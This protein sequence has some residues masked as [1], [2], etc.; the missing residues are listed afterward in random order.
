MRPGRNGGEW[1]SPGRFLSVGATDSHYTSRPLVTYYRKNTKSTRAH[2]FFIQNVRV[3]AYYASMEVRLFYN[4]IRPGVGLKPRRE[5]TRP[6]LPLHARHCPVLEAGSA[7]GFMVYA[8]LE[9]KESLFIEYEGEGRYKF[10]YYLQTQ[11]G[12]P[13]PIFQ[14]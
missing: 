6:L 7:L 13:T 5:G 10:V 9:P 14:V 2:Y 4:S 3:M 11:D 12:K 8:P 1:L